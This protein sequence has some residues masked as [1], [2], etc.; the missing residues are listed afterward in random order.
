MYHGL[1]N[2]FITERLFFL[3]VLG[4]EFRV[5]CLIASALTLGLHYQAFYLHLLFRR[6]LMIWSSAR[7]RPQ[8]YYCT[9]LIAVACFTL[10]RFLRNSLDNFIPRLFLTCKPPI[11]TP[12]VAVIAAMSCCDAQHNYRGTS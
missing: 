4:F 3:T 2:C 11:F 12:Q 8:S 10:P 1:I 6:G 9:S 7:L 5:L